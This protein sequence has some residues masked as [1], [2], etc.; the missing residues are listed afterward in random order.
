MCTNSQFSDT[1]PIK[2]DGDNSESDLQSARQK[3][4]GLSKE[5]KIAIAAS[6]IGVAAICVAVFIFC[7]IK[8][9][10]VGKHEKLVEDA[11]FEKNQSEL[12]AYRSE[13]SRMRSE[14]LAEARAFGTSP[15]NMGAS[16]AQQSPN[17]G[18]ANS[19]YAKSNYA[20]SISTYG[21]GRGYQRY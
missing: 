10:R 5:A 7:C 6:V 20:H 13:M 3:W 12:M 16:V 4:N 18:Y 1:K 19:S 14:K 2:L 11:K 9:R 17:I 8:Q 21:S 15:G